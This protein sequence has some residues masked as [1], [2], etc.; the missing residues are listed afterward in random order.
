MNLRATVQGRA[1]AR[2]QR[3]RTAR[4]RPQSPDK[5]PT[6]SETLPSVANDPTPVFKLG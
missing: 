2:S 1:N 3:T 5:I 6:F 4:A